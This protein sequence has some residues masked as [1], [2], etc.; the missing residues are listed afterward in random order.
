MTIPIQRSG[1]RKHVLLW[2]ILGEC[3]SIIVANMLLDRINS[4]ETPKAL[5]PEQGKIG[6]FMPRWHAPNYYWVIAIL[7]ILKRKLTRGR[8]TAIVSFSGG[9]PPKWQKMCNLVENYGYKSNI[10]IINCT[11]RP[12]SAIKIT[13]DPH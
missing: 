11:P 8:G 1:H 6:Y 12:F 3:D 13:R 7:G 4:L 9:I 10:K 2:S 5:Q